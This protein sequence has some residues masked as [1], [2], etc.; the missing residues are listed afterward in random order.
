MKISDFLNGI[1]KYMDFKHCVIRM[2]MAW[3]FVCLVEAVVIAITTEKQL[4]NIAYVG[5]ISIGMHMISVIL[6][7]ICFYVLLEV[8]KGKWIEKISLIVITCLYAFFAVVQT[9]DIYFCTGMTALLVFTFAYAFEDVNTA[10]ISVKKRTCR[11]VLIVS[12]LFFVVFT[13]GCT[14]L[15]V[16][17]YEAPNF[18]M[19]LF[20]QM[21]HYMKTTFTMNTTSERDRLLSH[22]CVH[23]SPDF[24]L[25]LPFYAVISSPVTL[26]VMQAAV[27][28][29]GLIPL[30]GICKNHGL[31]GLEQ[32]F[33]GAA[34]CF[35]PVMS[36]GCFY[37]I[38]ENLFLP[39]FILCLLYFFEKESW[40]GILI[41]M[42]LL[43]GVKEDAAIYGV[44]IALYMLL[45]KRR[46]VW[47]KSVT[48]IVCC[49]V[50]F[51]FTTVLLAHIG[52]GVMT[53]R[54]NNMVYGENGSML[55]MVR[56]VLVNPA[57]LV[58]QMFT[59]EKLEFLLQTLGSL[60]FIPLLS[61]R[62]TR[63]ILFGP[64]VL[65]NLMSDYAY[66]HN[67]YFQYVFGSGALLFYLAVMNAADLSPKIRSRAIP[68]MAAACV[69]FF[70]ATVWQRTAIVER[71][72]DSYNQTVYENF[73]EALSLIPEDA[74]VTAT[75][76]LCPALSNH[77]ILYELHYTDKTTEYIVLDLRVGSTD[78]NAAD[79]LEN[80]RYETVYYRACQIAVFRDLEFSQETQAG[81]A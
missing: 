79:Y 63:Y 34:Y 3:C 22:M 1:K 58:K 26:Q 9:P 30:M 28:A 42:V 10:K 19:G 69:M 54:F 56:T 27:I 60:C 2:I 76:F 37:D 62:W 44:F 70:G 49:F 55:G 50:Y 81:I 65:F 7:F 71:Y 66:F 67:I 51:I 15:R 47:K 11:I 40:K 75:T 17:A 72:T 25:L 5:E 32:M 57:Y 6:V 12:G 20:S 23:I 77:D 21:F 48:V 33:I 43:F 74:T 14:A 46:A 41:S 31:S 52:D 73:K 36:G 53:Y 16:L 68:M 4:D 64:F 45:E 80:P 78:Y 29:L 24:Y 39:L 61:K 18:D 38:H 35:Y 59:A 13:G 8:L